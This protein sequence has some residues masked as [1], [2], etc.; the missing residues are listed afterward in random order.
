MMHRYK[1]RQ[2]I[3]TRKNNHNKKFKLGMLRGGMGSTLSE[4]KGWGWGEKT[5]WRGDQEGGN[6]WNV[7]K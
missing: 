3:H 4:A 7:N 6:I 2:N 5:S 1:C